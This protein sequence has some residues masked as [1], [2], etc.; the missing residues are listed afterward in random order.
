MGKRGRSAGGTMHVI[1]PAPRRFPNP[2]PGMTENARTVWKR[3]VHAFPAD[4]F[5]PFQYD[6]LRS[7][8][9]A[10]NSHKVAMKHIAKQ[11][12]VITQDNGVT[13][14]NPWVGVAIKMSAQMA[15]LSTKLGLNM[16]STLKERGKIPKA[17]P[18]ASKRDGLLFGGDRK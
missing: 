2:Q 1:E 18:A 13:K 17:A 12:E 9:E 15:T 3:I 5:Q 8:C 14:E 4:H 6:L 7:Y 16:N 10:S 11:G